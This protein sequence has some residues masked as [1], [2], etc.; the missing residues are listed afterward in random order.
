VGT[1]TV[2]RRRFLRNSLAAI[3]GTAVPV[4]AYS[5]FIEPNH[6]TVEKIE[7]SIPNLPEAFDGFRIVQLSDFH[8]GAYTGKRQ[9]SAAVKLANSLKPDLIVLTGDFITA[10]DTE[11]QVPVTHPV[12]TETVECAEVLSGLSATEGVLGC[13]GN[14]DQ[15]VSSNYVREVFGSFRIK[16]LLNENVPI[17]RSGKKLWI[18]GVDDGVVGKP[19]FPRTVQGIPRDEPSILLA[20]D[21]DLAD[22]AAK[23]PLAAQLSGHSHGGQVRLP[24]LG[25]LY[26]PP[27]AEKYPY[28]YYRIRNMHLYTNRGIGT[29][30]LPYRFNSPPELTVAML[31]SV[32]RNPQ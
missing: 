5:Q 14:H 20:H 7:F 24:L 28:G 8:Y 10:P 4:A 32:P 11:V 1:T 18:A 16:L 27:L 31:K 19:D 6:L 21:P 13:L 30:V 25:S 12:F 22:E 26:L 9:I 15:A 23:Y 17:E 2:S 3:A 29:V